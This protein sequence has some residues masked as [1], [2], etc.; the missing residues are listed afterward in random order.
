MLA[1]CAQMKAAM[2]EPV[3]MERATAAQKAFVILRA[4]LYFAVS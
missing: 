4:C 1:G 3:D 2:S